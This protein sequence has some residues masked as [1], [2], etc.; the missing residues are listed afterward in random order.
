[1]TFNSKRPQESREQ[2][3]PVGVE[4]VL[5]TKALSSCSETLR[6][7]GGSSAERYM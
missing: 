5:P 6:L 3:L 4:D 7:L 2:H 1:V